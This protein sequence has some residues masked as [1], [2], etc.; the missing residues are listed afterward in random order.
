MLNRCLPGWYCWNRNSCR[1]LNL[2]R[3]GTLS[4]RPSINFFPR[5][6][7]WLA[8]MQTHQC[9]LV[10]LHSFQQELLLCWTRKLIHNRLEVICSPA[11]VG[12]TETQEHVSWSLCAA[13][14]YSK[15]RKAQ[16]SSTLTLSDPSV[17][18]SLKY[19]SIC[20]QGIH[21]ELDLGT[22]LRCRCVGLII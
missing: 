10:S 15:R 12:N 8:Y 16:I 21:V 5:I 18:A 7:C 9:S 13:K 3:T 19:P 14:T 4:T 1:F 11:F 20:A 17:V 22:E 6:S 2:S